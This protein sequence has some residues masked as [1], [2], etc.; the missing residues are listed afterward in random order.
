MYYIFIVATSLDVYLI[1]STGLTG[2]NIIEIRRLLFLE[3][4]NI[5]Y[6]R[7]ELNLFKSEILPT[8]TNF[9]NK[10]ELAPFVNLFKEL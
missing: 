2:A 7:F 9:Y 8:N 3:S 5:V 4:Q 10:K 1:A 6:E